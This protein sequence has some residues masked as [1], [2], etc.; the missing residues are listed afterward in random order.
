VEALLRQLQ[1]E[2]LVLPALPS[3]RPMWA[4]S[5]GYRAV[6]MAEAAALDPLVITLDT[7][8]ARLLKKALRAL[9]PCARA[10]C[11][12]PSRTPLDACAFADPS[13]T[14]AWLAGHGLWHRP[15]A[16]WL[17]VV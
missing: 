3:L 7:S 15:S 13:L 9:A 5:F 16:R 11:H 6:S 1:V 8:S 10:T 4:A 17:H 12:I 14:R 2:H